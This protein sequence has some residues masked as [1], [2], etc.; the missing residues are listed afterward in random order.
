MCIRDRSQGFHWTK[1]QATLHPFVVYF[2]ENS[3]VIPKSFCVISN[4]L[5]YNT[6]VVHTFQ[7]HLINQIKE[8]IPNIEKIIYFR[9]GASSQYKN[10]KNF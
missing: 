4:Y 3:K 6:V 8:K 10:R 1:S 9:D 2:K 5:E 7:K